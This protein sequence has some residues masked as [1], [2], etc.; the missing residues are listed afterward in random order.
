M[1]ILLGRPGVYRDILGGEWAAIIV[2]EPHPG[3]VY[4]RQ[5]V[6]VYCFPRAHGDPLSPGDDGGYINTQL[7]L[8]A[9]LLGLDAFTPHHTAAVAE[10]AP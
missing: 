8:R 3:E 10:A 1:S 7:N 2:G 4:D 5:P 6:R 9:G